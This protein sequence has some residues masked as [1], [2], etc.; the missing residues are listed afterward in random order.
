MIHIH[1]CGLGPADTFR[2]CLEPIWC[3]DWICSL[4]L[5]SQVLPAKCK[6]LLLLTIET[7][8]M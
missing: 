6:Q 2:W 7:R 5:M 4:Q 3:D 1:L 8:R